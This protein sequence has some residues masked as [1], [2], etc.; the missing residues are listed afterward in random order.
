MLR[1]AKIM[2]VGGIAVLPFTK[3]CAQVEP[4]PKDTFFLA[5]KKGLLGTLGKSLSTEPPGPEPVKLVN[6]FIKFT[7]KQIRNIEIL[8]LGF[9]RNINDTTLIKNS[10]GVVVA[11][12]L[13]KSTREKIIQNNLFF[14]EGELIQ[15]YLLADNER[16]LRELV[17]IQDARILIDR[18]PGNDSQVDVVVITK[19][20]FSIGA[21]VDIGGTSKFRLELKDENFGGTGSRV[22]GSFLYDKERNP[23]LGYAA[24]YTKRNVKGSF[25][26]W[27]LGFNTYRNAF[28]TGKEQESSLYT[29][30]EKPLVTPYIPW[31]GSL[32]L[33]YNHTANNYQ[34]DS[35]YNSYIRY[36]YHLFDA[37]FGYNFGSRR[38]LYKNKTMRLRKLLAI[39][40]LYR[41]F[42]TQPDS[43]KQF[44]NPA[45]AD[46][47]GVLAS[48]NLFQQ[49]FYR[50]NF[51]YGF[52]RNED[53]PEG[54][55]V[56][57]IGGW[58]N[59]EGRSRPY[60]GL[61][62]NRSHY[63]KKG[64]YSAYTLRLGG[65]V[66]EKRWE[67]IDILFNVDHFTRLNKWR[68][69]WLNR[70]FISMGFTKQIRQVFNV[71]LLLKS[72][73]GLPYF[74]LDPYGSD[75]RAILKGESVF[76]NTN[77]FLGFRMAPFVFTDLCLLR[78]TD[79]EFS[80]SDLYSALGGGVRI[81]NEN[82]IFGTIEVR[83]Y[84]FP[85]VLPG[86]PQFKINIATDLRYK[87]SSS[88]VKRPDFTTPN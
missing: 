32:D 9:E 30:L 88:F 33:A 60:Y 84:F 77:K 25:I 8:R 24:E 79:R 47:T 5:K 51:I 71:P 12:A 85:R 73:F 31:I 86:M 55:G 38:L 23:N 2:L 34:N 3:L 37:W 74:D 43:I 35:V 21:G 15:P 54:F 68:G 72:G 81:R 67:D 11:N 69:P 62:A 44:F 87:Y 63:N 10:V 4:A 18:V 75:F 16:Y 6:P 17:F 59:K 28:N 29:H 22:S 83:G 45:Y 58:T 52:G 19:D 13:H 14:K 70:N 49:D 66:F 48:F 65:Y 76:Y 61:E 46:I 20:N 27:T 57:V 50:T 36:N 80:K 40:G 1:W 39:R 26:D 7:G 42:T 78:Q 53:V 82:L 41:N 64:F 56:S